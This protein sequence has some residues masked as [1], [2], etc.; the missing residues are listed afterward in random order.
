[1]AKQVIK[2]PF[3]FFDPERLLIVVKKSLSG[4]CTYDNNGDSNSNA[5]YPA[6]RKA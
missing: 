3:G 2:K 5:D 6:A 1:M 4:C